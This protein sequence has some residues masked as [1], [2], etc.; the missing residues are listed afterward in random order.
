MIS[1]CNHSSK[2]LG[3]SKPITRILASG[4]VPEEYVPEEY[5]PLDCGGF[6]RGKIFVDRISNHSWG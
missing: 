5:K 4:N 3:V 6:A 2:L 1:D